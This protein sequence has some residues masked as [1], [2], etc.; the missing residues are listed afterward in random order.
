MI[1]FTWNLVLALVWMALTGRFTADN[2]LIGLFAGYVV[3]AYALRGRPE[4]AN[5]IAKVP[6]LIRFC[7]W[8]NWALLRSN[9]KVAYD[10]LTPTHHMRPGVIAYPLEVRRDGEITILAN[11]IS[12]TPGS[13]SLDVSSDG[14]VLYIHVMYLEDEAQTVREIKVLEQRLLELLR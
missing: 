5:Y 2:L 8:F 11:L 1:A 4:F 9:L 7:F 6:R 10:V 14:S 12:L 13:L 3:L